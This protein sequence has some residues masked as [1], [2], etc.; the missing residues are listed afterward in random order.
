MKPSYVSAS[1]I[2][3]SIVLALGGIALQRIDLWSHDEDFLLQF[4]KDIYSRASFNGRPS[5]QH[6]VNSAPG[7]SS[8][9]YSGSP[10]K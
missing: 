3:A 1:V 7:L 4:R 5:R 10:R 8:V 9:L 6:I 2:D